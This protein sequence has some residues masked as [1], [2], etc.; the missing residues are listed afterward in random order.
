MKKKNIKGTFRIIVIL[1]LI[2]MVS[3]LRTDTAYAEWQAEASDSL[4]MIMRKE[5]SFLQKRSGNFCTESE[6]EEALRRWGIE[7]GDP[8]GIAYNYKCVGFDCQAPSQ[9]HPG[10]T[11]VREPSQ[12]TGSWQAEDERQRL[13]EEKRQAH[14]RQ[15]RELLRNLK[16]SPAQGVEIKAPSAGTGQLQ[17]KTYSGTGGKALGSALKQL[18]SV[19]GSSEEARKTDDLEAA[20]KRSEFKVRPH[21]GIPAESVRVPDVPA[22]TLT[23]AQIQARDH[24]TRIR[25]TVVSKLM[26]AQSTLEKTRERTEKTKEDIAAKKDELIEIDKRFNHRRYKKESLVVKKDNATR[27]LDDLEKLAL[28][29]EREAAQLNENADQQRRKYEELNKQEKNV[30]S[31]PEHAEEYM[32]QM[33]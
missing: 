27:E 5:G 20:R 12:Q 28:E 21:G 3:I 15:K 2:Y 9:Q 24:I 16:G 23:A 25:E 14:D 32:R 1:S 7:S 22:P 19:A 11:I 18:E 29:L 31:N 33:R 4:I 8:D 26:E 17:L 30:L 13:V 10:G 6:C